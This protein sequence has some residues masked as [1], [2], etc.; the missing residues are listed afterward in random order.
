M[1]TVII[2]AAGQ[3]TRMNSKT[4]KVLHKVGNK[5]LLQHSIDSSKV[6]VEKINVIVG[7]N[8]QLIKEAIDDSKVNWILQKEQLGTGH[9]VQQATPYIE[10]NSMCLILYADV[11]L[12]QT[13]TIEELL[14]R[15]APQGLLFLV[16]F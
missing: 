1:N 8:S 13:N 4:A 11:P 6:L 15:L 16:L 14:N 12:L 10:D 7:Q 3:G 9:A 5:Y 2:L